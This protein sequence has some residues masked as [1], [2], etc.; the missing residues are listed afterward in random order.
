MTKFHISNFTENIPFN[1][2]NL[3]FFLLA[4][5]TTA[6][7]SFQ[8]QLFRYDTV[9]GSGFV[10]KSRI[11]IRRTNFM[12]IQISN[13]SSRAFRYLT[14]IQQVY[15]EDVKRYRYTGSLKEKKV[16][17]LPMKMW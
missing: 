2:K 17:Y 8:H 14:D 11:W 9:A 13:T 1:V 16:E 3:T 6:N 5:H 10:F 4:W 12:R 15:L 7:F